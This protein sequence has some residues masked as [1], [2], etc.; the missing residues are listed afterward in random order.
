MPDVHIHEIGST[1]SEVDSGSLSPAL[2][3]QI[4]QTLLDRLE[5]RM[6][7]ER[8]RQEEEWQQA[9]EGRGH[10]ERQKPQER[11]ASIRIDFLADREAER[12]G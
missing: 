5:K 2:T 9:R 6:N 4:I 12:N 7:E 10:I 11:L 3:E 1:M 8:R